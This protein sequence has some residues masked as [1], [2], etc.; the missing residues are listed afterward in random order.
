MKDRLS[1]QTSDDGV[2][3]VW[4]T[5]MHSLPNGRALNYLRCVRCNLFRTDTCGGAESFSSLCDENPLLNFLK[6]CSYCLHVLLRGDCGNAGTYDERKK[7]AF[8]LLHGVEKS[9]TSR[10]RLCANVLQRYPK[11]R[12]GRSSRDYND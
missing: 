11:R 8:V 2:V 10:R 9:G 1:L 6:L 3:I 7:N 12:M 5:R 4:I